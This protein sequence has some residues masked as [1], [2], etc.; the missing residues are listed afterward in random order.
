M[1][2][3]QFYGV[4]YLP[5]QIWASNYDKTTDKDGLML[6]DGEIEESYFSTNGTLI[7]Y[8]NYKKGTILVPDEFK[9]N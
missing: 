5:H 2:K 6:Y 9:I 3:I 1:K 7:H 8:V 4:S